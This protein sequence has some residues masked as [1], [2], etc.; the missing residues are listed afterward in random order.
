MHDVNKLD[1]SVPRLV[2]SPHSGA[3]LVVHL[4]WATLGLEPLLAASTDGS[5]GAA[6]RA[7]A[8]ELACHVV[9]VGHTADE[10][11]VVVRHPPTV[12]VSELT[13]LLKAASSRAWNRRG[14]ALEWNPGY[15][16]RTCD[17]ERLEAVLDQVRA[18]RPVEQLA[19]AA[20]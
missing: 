15:W 19:L 8:R 20:G 12:C 3:S 9:A 6:L 7:T 10:V 16:A 2:M 17:G 13:H 14:S 1:F 5:L 18:L 4:A 11:H